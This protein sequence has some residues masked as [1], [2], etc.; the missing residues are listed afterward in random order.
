MHIRVNFPHLTSVSLV[1]GNLRGFTFYASDEHSRFTLFPENLRHLSME[2]SEG[3]DDDQGTL[4]HQFSD[5][6]CVTCNVVAAR[7]LKC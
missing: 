2:N 5:L 1:N 7:T 3:L 6:A 4:S